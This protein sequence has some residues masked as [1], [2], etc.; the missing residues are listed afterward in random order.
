MPDNK[1]NKR[2]RIGDRV[3]I[4]PR[5]RKQI[6]VADFWHRGKHCRQSLGTSNQKIARQK[7]VQLETKLAHGGLAAKSVAKTLAE[8]ADAFVAHHQTENRRPKTIVKYRGFLKCFV[9]FATAHRLAKP[10]DVTALHIDTFRAQ[11]CLTHSPK[12][13]HNEG[14]ILKSFFRYCRQR[15]LV[16]ESPLV[17]MVFKKPIAA[18]RGGPSLEQIEA[19]LAAVSEPR[20][21]QLA[22]LAFGGLRS[23]ELQRL[24]HLDVDLDA[25]WVHV[26]S[27]VGA[28][29]KTGRSRKLPIHPRL[30]PLLEA[31]GAPKR[32]W[33]FEAPPSPKYPAGGHYIN[34]K[35]LNDE[36][37]ALMKELEL[38]AGRNGG[39]T[40]HSLRHSF[41][42]I[43]VN[44]G[45]PQRVIDTWMGH[46]SDRS[47]ASIYYK[48]A[49][50][51][52]QRFMK[53]VPF[54]T[55]EPAADAGDR[56]VE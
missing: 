36:F 20:F 48:L 16:H 13:M 47:M 32:T 23:G 28:E 50:D 37:V 2:I 9:E 49:D 40:V 41:E 46:W 53:M 26:V 56:E 1:D 54:G 43:C 22:L 21:T 45:I 14:V 11:R 5:G 38:P 6:Y 39:F 30:R 3:T 27:R 8:A 34:N 31:M 55:G 17:D 33:F 10:G 35:H 4:Y 51:E 19:I 15:R 24:Q 7:A 29:T 52:S 12:S 42:T 25:N 44:A 18:P